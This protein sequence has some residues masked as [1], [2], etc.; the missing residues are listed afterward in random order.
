MITM[1]GSAVGDQILTLTGQK[2]AYIAGARWV[3]PAGLMMQSDAERAFEARG[4]R[5]RLLHRGDLGAAVALL[6]IDVGDFDARYDTPDSVP[7]VVV[8]LRATLTRPG[9]GFIAEQTFTTREPAAE[10]R[11]APIVAAFDKAVTDVLGQVVDW[12]EANAPAAAPATTTQVV[13]SPSTSTRSIDGP[14]PH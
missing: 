14:A 1:P 4:Q 9:G 12:T 8:S 7:T 10:N 13:S 3:I 11:V 5:I 6:H 2:A